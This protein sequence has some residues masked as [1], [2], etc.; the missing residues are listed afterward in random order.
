MAQRAVRIMGVYDQFKTSSF[1]DGITACHIRFLQTALRKST[2]SGRWSSCAT[3]AELWSPLKK[4]LLVRLSVL[5][6][7]LLK[8]CPMGSASCVLIY[9]V[10]I[11]YLNLQ[12]TEIYLLWEKFVDVILWHMIGVAVKHSAT[13]SIVRLKIAMNN[14]KDNLQN[15]RFAF[16]LIFRIKIT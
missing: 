11:V 12:I 3:F 4:S 14:N 10:V 13:I 16:F 9:L 2:P 15:F 8:I 5:R 6:L 7:V 1:F